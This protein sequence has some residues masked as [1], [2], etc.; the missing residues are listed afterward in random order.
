VD[1][2]FRY[3]FLLDE[4]GLINLK[5][6]G[7][8]AEPIQY[9]AGSSLYCSHCDHELSTEMLQ[10]ISEANEAH[11]GPDTLRQHGQ[12]LMKGPTAEDIAISAQPYLL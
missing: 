2:E 3:D 12:A 1:V 5:K 11:Y 10:A 7:L 8:H 9:I 4:H 6:L